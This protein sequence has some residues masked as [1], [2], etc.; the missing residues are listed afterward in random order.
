MQGKAWSNGCIMKISC[1]ID[2]IKKATPNDRGCLF[3]LACSPAY[4]FAV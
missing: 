2:K 1:G 3:N 4:N